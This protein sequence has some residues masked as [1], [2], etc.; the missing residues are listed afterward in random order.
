[1]STSPSLLPNNR[2]L[3]CR[4]YVACGQPLRW[5]SKTHP[6]NTWRTKRLIKALGASKI[7]YADRGIGPLGG[8]KN[9][10]GS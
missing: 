3:L 6:N 4:P 5:C 1:M 8:C 9:S 2:V 10:K 7:A